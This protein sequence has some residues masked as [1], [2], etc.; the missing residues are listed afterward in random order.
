[1]T[2]V[3]PKVYRWIVL[4]NK[5]E[6]ERFKNLPGFKDLPGNSIT[7]KEGERLR[8]WAGSHLSRGARV[9]TIGML[10]L[11]R[12]TRYCPHIRFRCDAVCWEMGPMAFVLEVKTVPCSIFSIRGRLRFQPMPRSAETHEAPNR[13]NREESLIQSDMPEYNNQNYRPTSIVLFSSLETS[14]KCSVPGRVSLLT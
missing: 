13:S 9:H 5:W 14:C 10:H 3:F 11:V 12:W 4:L 8:R 2:L 1:M 7:T 6:I